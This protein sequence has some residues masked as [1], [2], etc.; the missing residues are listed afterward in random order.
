[1][2][3]PATTLHRF[4]SLS[5]FVFFCS[6]A[7]AQFELQ[8]QKPIGKDNAFTGF[9]NI[10]CVKQVNNR[11]FI[12]YMVHIDGNDY[13]GISS[14]GTNDSD[15]YS[16]NDLSINKGLKNFTIVD[17]AARTG[18]TLVCFCNDYNDYGNNQPIPIPAKMIFVLKPENRLQLE[19][20]YDEK[21]AQIEGITGVQYKSAFSNTS[22]EMVFAV[23]F[24]G[25]DKDY[26]NLFVSEGKTIKHSITFAKAT[27]MHIWWSDDNNTLVS[28]ETPFTTG[29]SNTYY[30]VMVLDKELHT[31]RKYPDVLNYLNP[32]ATDR[33]IS[34]DYRPDF[35]LGFVNRQVQ[36]IGKQNYLNSFLFNG[37]ADGTYNKLVGE[38]KNVVIGASLLHDSNNVVADQY[39][40][41][42]NTLNNWVVSVDTTATGQHD[43][44]VFSIETYT[45]MV[46]ASLRVGDLD[47][48]SNPD[49]NY[50]HDGMGTIDPVY[51][52]IKTFSRDNDNSVYVVSHLKTG[53]YHMAGIYISKWKLNSNDEHLQKDYLT[54]KYGREIYHDTKTLSAA[55]T[56]KK[57]VLVAVD[58]S[59]INYD[60]KDKLVN[61]EIKLEDQLTPVPN[62]WF[63]KGTVKVGKKKYT[64]TKIVIA[65]GG[66]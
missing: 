34:I 16:M 39:A 54:K 2:P 18:D 56:K 45:G 4:F 57:L 64:F 33:L 66:N 27:N 8:W 7:T 14:L 26:V 48:K 51:S 55:D 31:I 28:V 41:R 1:M 13:P 46:L 3:V 49:F 50:K 37:F 44:L 36:S 17:M 38:D 24:H 10:T 21:L 65:K 62:T 52:V 20:Y 43:Q 15:L 30:E 12:A 53:L 32:D 5:L 25:P 63:W 9:K 29:S 6:A 11:N 19:N 35:H 59:D 22:G 58:E 61:E 40:C 60:K 23:Q 47:S 42:D